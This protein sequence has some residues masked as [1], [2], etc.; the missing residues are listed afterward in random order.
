[1]SRCGL[2][3]AGEGGA[4]VYKHASSSRVADS[5]ELAANKSVGEAGLHAE[6]WLA[7]RAF[8]HF[9]QPPRCGG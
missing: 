3:G 8:Q 5:S 7:P 6:R 2:E 9:P 1:M 4:Q